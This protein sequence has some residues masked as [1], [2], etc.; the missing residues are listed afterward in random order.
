MR[1]CCAA[2]ELT[3]EEITAKKAERD[4]C[5]VCGPIADGPRA[6]LTGTR[7]ALNG[8]GVLTRSRKFWAQGAWVAADQVEKFWDTGGPE[9][10]EWPLTGSK[11]SGTPAA[12]RTPSY[13]TAMSL[14]D[15]SQ[16]WSPS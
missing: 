12:R 6:C 7:S 8:L 13:S 2:C 4:Y 3:E 9:N 10:S 5:S 14:G 16:D 1:A 15:P 11:N